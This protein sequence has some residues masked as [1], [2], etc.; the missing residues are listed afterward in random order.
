[1]T[2]TSGLFARRCVAWIFSSWISASRCSSA[3]RSEQPRRCA[4]SAICCADS[5][6]LT[7]RARVCRARVRAAP[8]AAASTCRCPDRRRS[9]PRRPRPDRRPARG[10]IRRCRSA[11]RGTSTPRYRRDACTWRACRE[12]LKAVR[13]RR[14]R[15]RFHQRV[16]RAACGH[17][18]CHFGACPPHS[19]QMYSVFAFATFAT[20]DPGIDC[21][22]KRLLLSDL[23]RAQVQHGFSRG[24]DALSLGAH[25]ARTGTRG[26]IAHISS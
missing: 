1:M 9:A 20:R 19:V 5:S 7:R 14:L 24:C 18:P 22:L 8:A 23:T 21:W 6:P 10:R 13:R 11:E 17:W 26:A 3:L 16:P 2:A 15:D 25:S 12:R 4:R